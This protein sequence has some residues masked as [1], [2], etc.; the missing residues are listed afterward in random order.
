MK[1]ASSST[2]SPSGNVMRAEP[3]PFSWEVVSRGSMPQVV[4]ALREIAPRAWREAMKPP[5]RF[6][7]TV[8]LC[9]QAETSGV[10]VAKTTFSTLDSKGQWKSPMVEFYG[11]LGCRA[12]QILQ[13]FPMEWKGRAL[14]YREWTLLAISRSGTCIMPEHSSPQYQDERKSA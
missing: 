7:V 13:A 14:P 2:G 10:M 9:G 4:K 5:L 12:S 8:R 11:L 1:N 3:A 6:A